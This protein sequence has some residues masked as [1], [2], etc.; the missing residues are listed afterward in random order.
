MNQYSSI[1]ELQDYQKEKLKKLIS[2]LNE[3][4]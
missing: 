3:A 2:T 4:K 1:S